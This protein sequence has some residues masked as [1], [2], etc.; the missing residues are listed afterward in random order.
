MGDRS[1]K[2]TEFSGDTAV[3]KM[4]IMEYIYHVEMCRIAGGWT[5]AITAEKVKLKLVGSAR[6][7]L[8]NRIRAETEGLGAF[9]PA[10][11]AGRRPPGLRALLITRFMPQQTPGE[12]ERLRATLTQGETESV[13]TFYDRVESIQFILD[14]ELP[15]DFRRDNKA[16][17]DIV[18]ARQVR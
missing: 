12:Q 14:L 3:D 18:H 1:V 11:I 6:T 5:D 8:Q 2:L 13:H 17:Y 7:W 16:A 10:L 15:E 9:D 4:T